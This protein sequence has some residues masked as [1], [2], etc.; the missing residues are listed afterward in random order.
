M[1]V[2]GFT[3][4]GVGGLWFLMLLLAGHPEIILEFFVYQVRLFNT[5]DAGHGG[6]FFYHWFVLLIGCFPASVLAIRAF[7][8]SAFDTPYQKHFK[9]WM[10]ILFWLV[11]LLFSIVKT[12][13]IHYSSLCYFPLSFFAAYA[14]DKLLS[15]ELRWK[16]YSGVLLAV[17]ACLLGIA[18]S[19]LPVIDRFKDHIIS[20]GL[21]EDK[22]AEANLSAA[23]QWSG[24]EWLLGVLLIAGTAVMLFLIRKNRLMIALPGLFIV[25]LFCVNMATVIVTP[26]IEPYSQGAAIEFYEYLQEKD[27]YVETLGFKSYAHLFYSH[28]KPSANK[29]SYKIEWL[30]GGHADK[31]VYF[32]SKNTYE[33]ELRSYYPHLKVLYRKNGFVFW[34]G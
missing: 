22:F 24:I 27:C 15:G 1:F 18:L 21:I 7:R 9:T 4:A 20:K 29:E 19:A 16:R 26:R 33:E 28:K 10:L 31:P 17:I 8:K 32:V 2:F 34:Q 11:L 12:K 6:P 25:S 5:Q 13:I 14:M 30:L 3:V 23:V